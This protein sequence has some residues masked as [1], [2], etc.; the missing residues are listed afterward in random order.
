MAKPTQLALHITLI[1]FVLLTIASSVTSYIFYDKYRIEVDATL[2]AVEKTKEV[3]QQRKKADEERNRLKKLVGKEATEPVDVIMKTFEEHQ[4][5]YGGAL[6]EETRDYPTMLQ[7]QRDFIQTLEKEK[8]EFENESKT[9]QAA[10]QKSKKDAADRVDS[11]EQKFQGEKTRID[12]LHQKYVELDK[13]YK[14]KQASIEEQLEDTRQE[15]QNLKTEA[16]AREDALRDQSNER[17]R[18]I[19]DL[20]EELRP[21]NQWES[22]PPDGK[23]LSINQAASTVF[24]DLG[25]KDGLRRQTTFAVVPYDVKNALNMQPKGALEVV[26]VIDS[27]LAEARI[28]DDTLDNPI[29][30]GDR[31]VSKIFNPGRPEHFAVVGLIDFNGDGR[32]DLQQLISLI[33]RNG[34]VVD[35]WVDDNGLR[36]GKFEDGTRFLIMGR[37]PDEKSEERVRESYK[38][39]LKDAEKFPVGRIDV[40]IFLDYIGFRGRVRTSEETADGLQRRGDLPFRRRPNDR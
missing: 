3:E 1:V 16:K 11:Y 13:D 25:S 7:N 10:S 31:I 24:I 17:S 4:K 8:T 32:S 40:D 39:M 38:K 20:Q 34:G 37:P 15:A 19:A 28:I 21:Y 26:R 30:P 5:I 23:V 2:A 33:R 14:N 18:K 22:E 12:D 9:A 27:H 6:P 29:I 35:A 36:K